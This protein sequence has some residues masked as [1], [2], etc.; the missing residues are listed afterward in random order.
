MNLL[1]VLALTSSVSLAGADGETPS[2]EFEPLI[3]MGD[4][5]LDNWPFCD[6]FVVHTDQGFALA[7][8]QSGLWTFTEGDHV[9]GLADRPGQ[10]TIWLSGPILSGE[11]IVDLEAVR[12]D[13]PT[14]QDTF[15][16]RCKIP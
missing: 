1:A 11:M 14:A 16:R 2:A 9:Y 7:R 6:F 15:Y 4:V 12:V 10:Q 13:L 3:G 5:A 8:W